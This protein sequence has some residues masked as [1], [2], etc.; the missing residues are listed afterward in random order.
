MGSRGT[1]R[2]VP[3][4]AGAVTSGPL[5]HVRSGVRGRGEIVRTL[6]AVGSCRFTLLY[7]MSCAVGLFAVGLGTPFWLLFTLGFWLVYCLAT[8]LL[9]RVADRV[10]DEINRVERTALCARVGFDRLRSAT[11]ALYGLAVVWAAAWIALAP[12]LAL[13]ALLSAALIISYGYSRGARLKRRRWLGTLALMTPVSLPMLTGWATGT[14]A[15]D[16]VAHGAPLALVAA[17]SF[18]ALVGIKDL[19]DVA[20]DRAIG[21]SSVWATVAAAG[22]L[23]PLVVASALAFVLLAG[24]VLGGVAPAAFTLLFALAPISGAVV[25]AAARVASVFERATAREAMY[26]YTAL[27]LALALACQGLA[28]GSL[29]AL[30]ASALGLSA[31]VL[32]S[33]HL[34]WTRMLTGRSARTWLRL[35]HPNNRGS[36]R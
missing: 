15:S 3:V 31:W 5:A 20:G 11:I 19:T 17:L 13:A 21:Y 34:H 22:R 25:V 30:L 16:V 29:A 28:S 7:W 10:E 18:G 26:Q 27:F 4:N 9:N 8:E 36:N 2:G 35:L 6:L 24:L 23:V 12:R 33:R 1:L 32:A 14:A